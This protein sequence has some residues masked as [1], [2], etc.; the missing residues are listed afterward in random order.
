MAKVSTI[1]EP[2]SGSADQVPRAYPP[3]II[4]NIVGALAIGGRGSVGAGDVGDGQVAVRHD[5]SLCVT[6]D[7]LVNA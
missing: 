4:D 6:A 5:G 2:L 7:K 1:R 3:E